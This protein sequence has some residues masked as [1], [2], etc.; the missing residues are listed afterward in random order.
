MRTPNL[1]FCLKDCAVERNWATVDSQLPD[2]Y[3]IHRYTSSHEWLLSYSSQGIYEISNPWPNEDTLRTLQAFSIDSALCKNME[4]L[5]IFLIFAHAERGSLLLIVQ[6]E[7]RVE[8]KEVKRKFA[9][10]VSYKS[11]PLELTLL[12]HAR[13]Q[14]SWRLCAVRRAHVFFYG[15]IMGCWLVD[16]A[17]Q[18][19]QS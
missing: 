19:N 9:K 5:I 7:G 12:V 6:W 8:R 17:T 18:L 10:I 1:I 13:H 15:C 11:L 3:Q 4:P 14:K 2:R 16:I